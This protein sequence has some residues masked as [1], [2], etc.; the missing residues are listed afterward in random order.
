MNKNESQT[1]KLNITDIDRL[2]PITVFV[3]DIAPGKGIV[4]IT[5]YGE[6]W[7]AYW[8]S[9]GDMT[10]KEFFCSCDEH[11]IANKLSNIEPRVYDI[12]AIRSQAE[13]R[14]VECWR[15]DPWND[16]HFLSEMY[17]PDMVDWGDS[18]P[19][20]P[21]HKYQYLCRIIKTVQQAFSEKP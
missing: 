5:C 13:D 7:T 2:D 4:T 20:K 19:K 18:L 14:G 9:I 6:A 8:G 21:N 10:I 3:E 16:Y 1:T 11:Y 15:D 12:D 17:G